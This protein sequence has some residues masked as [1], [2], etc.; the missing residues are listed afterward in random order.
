MHGCMPTLGAFHP[1][2]WR[3]AWAYEVAMESLWYVHCVVQIWLPIS[4]H[5]MKAMGSNLGT[6]VFLQKS[7]V[8]P[9]HVNGNSCSKTQILTNPLVGCNVA[10]CIHNVFKVWCLITPE[11][12]HILCHILKHMVTIYFIPLWSEMH[13]HLPLN[14]GRDVGA[15]DSCV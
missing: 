5:T 3:A 14:T 12:P 15:G 7:G 2:L 11:C 10:C 1:A 4:F 9:K 6:H 13:Y 8:L